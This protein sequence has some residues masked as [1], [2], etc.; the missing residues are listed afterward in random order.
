MQRTRHRSLRRT[1]AALTL[2]GA[3][4]GVVPALGAGSPTAAA[5]VA[6]ANSGVETPSPSNPAVPES[7]STGRWGTNTATFS[8][9][10]FG[11]SSGARFTR[12]TMTSR[13]SGDAKWVFAPVPVTGGTSYR[14]ADS[15]RATV[16]TDLVAE[17][18]TASGAAS[19]QFLASVPATA[20][21]TRAQA[22]F[23]APSGAVSVT[24]FHLVAQVG[25]LDTDDTTL[26]EVSAPVTT[27]PVTTVP[28]TTAPVTT[29]PA[30]SMIA[31]GSFESA[32]SA[33]RPA[34][35]NPNSWGTLR[36]T[37]SYPTGGAADGSRYAKVQVSSRTSG[38]A[39]WVHDAAP[40]SA[41]TPLRYVGRY[42]SNIV[43]SVVVQYLTSS[44]A[45][46]YVDITRPAAASSWT[47]IDVSFTPP[48]GSVS[49]RVFHVV[50]GVG[51]LDIDAVGLAAA[52]TAP[53]PTTTLPAPGFVN[54]IAALPGKFVGGYL[55][56]YQL[57]L[58]STLPPGYD[59]L[60]HSF[61]VVASDGGVS[62]FTSNGVS[63]AALAAEYR[64]RRAAGKPT[65]LSIG[66]SGGAQAGLTTQAQVDRFLVTTKA[67]I[68]EFGFT[69]IDWDLELD[70]PGGISAS[71]LA[72]ASRNLR[73]TYGSNFTVSVAPFGVEGIVS[74]Y[75]ALVAD[76]QRTGDISFVGYQ[77]YNDLT[78]TT[79]RVLDTMRSWMADTGIRP[80]QFV[81]GFWAGPWDWPAGYTM[82]VSAMVD[83]YRGVNA[84][85]PSLRG[86]YTWGVRTFDMVQGYPFVTALAPVVHS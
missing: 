73:A 3:A 80:D 22:A 4:A 78:P 66:G 9:P 26:E 53:A 13:T 85:Y 37:F 59:L 79:Q 24:V 65:I 61:G 81:L 54:G 10:S 12:V 19:Y 68:D 35:W 20:S 11:G 31:N 16:S 60:Y 46:S 33:T 2:A 64:A 7:W 86:V 84:V 44:G 76:L 23:T 56:A 29:V 5:S 75:K 70:V 49:A 27:A 48:A 1:A 6:V 69:G 18:R 34:G 51:W 39:K 15:Y 55:E 40:V 74:V 83:I 36:A 50:N 47:A 21:W 25:Q 67:L 77:F 45:A 63:R 38:D 58:P 32:A 71:G 43:T 14:F 8:Y 57:A 82:P 17:F 52:T 42:R 28:V 41:G 62:T 30:P 72:Q